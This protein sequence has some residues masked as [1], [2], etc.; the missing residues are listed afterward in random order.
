MLN[1]KQKEFLRLHIIEG[2]QI[3]EAYE[4]A[5]YRAR[6]QSAASAGSRFLQTPEA[7]AFIREMAGEQQKVA[8][9]F[10]EKFDWSVENFL[11]LGLT[12]F[13]ECRSTGDL[14]AASSQYERL[15]KVAGLW[16]ERTETSATHRLISDRPAPMDEQEWLSRFVDNQPRHPN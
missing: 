9:T 13:N 15:A 14:K 12:L 10:K 6:G 11:E 8:K 5:G 1:D 2:L 7:Q 16:V 3:G 4:R